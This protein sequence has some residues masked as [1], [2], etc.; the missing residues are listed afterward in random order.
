MFIEP[1]LLGKREEP[2]NDSRYVFQPKFD[3]HRLILSY[4][5]GQVRLYTRHN[6]EVTR[7]YPE[8]HN[9]PID[10]AIDVVLDGEVARMDEVGWIDFELIM[11]R[12]RLTKDPWIRV[13]VRTRPVIFYVYDVLQYNGKDTRGWPLT[14]RLAFL[15]RILKP[16]HYFSLVLSIE[17]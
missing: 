16:D 3:G 2:F 1:M 13:A 8:L 12:F 9:V 15:S 5:A 11:E 6:N 4:T 14:E 7:Q 17:G 10:G